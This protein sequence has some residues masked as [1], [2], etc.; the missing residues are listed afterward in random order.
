ML[1]R[2]GPWSVRYRRFLVAG[3]IA[4]IVIVGALAGA[5]EGHTDDAFNVPGTQSQQPLD[6]LDAKFPGPAAPTRGSVL[7][8]RDMSPRP[9]VPSSPV[10]V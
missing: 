2:I 4:V 1:C 6:L 10:L 5:F 7:R 3:W 8:T 9:V